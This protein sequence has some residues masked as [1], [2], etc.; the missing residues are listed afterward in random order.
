MLATLA[1]RRGGSLAIIGVFSV[2]WL[3]LSLDPWLP[4][5]PFYSQSTEFNAL[6]LVFSYHGTV[7]TLVVFVTLIPVL[8]VARSVSVRK[9]IARG[10]GSSILAVFALPF[11]AFFAAFS[12]PA[13]H[14]A[15]SLPSVESSLPSRT[16]DGIRTTGA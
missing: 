2:V 3:V 14:H 15:C 13:D 1:G 9:A 7:T 16:I 12:V 4:S 5:S 10:V 11:I 6:G 8:M